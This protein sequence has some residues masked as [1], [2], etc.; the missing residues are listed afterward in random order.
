MVMMDLSR[1]TTVSRMMYYRNRLNKRPFRI[2]AP[3]CSRVG[4]FLNFQNSWRKSITN[5]HILHARCIVDSQSLGEVVQ[6]NCTKS[7]VSC[8]LSF[9]T[10]LGVRMLIS[11]AAKNAGLVAKG[12]LCWKS[13]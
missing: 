5:L 9:S 13:S 12:T 4:A 6:G 8:A 1:S 2:S 11:P 10:D 3:F 7:F